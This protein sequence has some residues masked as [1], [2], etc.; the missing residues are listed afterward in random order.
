MEIQ[1]IDKCSPKER[2]K[3]TPGNTGPVFIGVY[4]L[5]DSKGG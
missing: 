5:F 4:Y 1:I 2:E 3:T